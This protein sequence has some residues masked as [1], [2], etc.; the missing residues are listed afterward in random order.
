M[1]PRGDM[2]P[3]GGIPQD[4]CPGQTS[5]WGKGFRTEVYF[6][7]CGIPQGSGTKV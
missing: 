7:L 2:P 3:R 6:L 4:T 5:L 1:S